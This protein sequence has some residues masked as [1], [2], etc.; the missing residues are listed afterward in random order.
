MKTSNFRPQNVGAPYG[1]MIIY[2]S[3]AAT[4]HI[5]SHRALKPSVVAALHRDIGFL[6]SNGSCSDREDVVQT[7]CHELTCSSPFLLPAKNK[8]SKSGRRFESI[9]MDRHTHRHSFCL[10]KSR[11]EDQVDMVPL[12][13][14]RHTH[15]FVSFMQQISRSAHKWNEVQ[16]HR[17]K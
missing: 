9:A 16:K 3:S 5:E 10:H 14:D 4:L 17:H 11:H 13:M 7:D 1:D 15:H 2:S 12:R 8:T 6:P